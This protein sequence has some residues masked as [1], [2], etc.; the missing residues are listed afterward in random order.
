MTDY[1]KIQDL[2]KILKTN[3]AK[4]YNPSEHLVVEEAIVKFKGSIIFKQ[5]IPKKMLFQHQNVQ[6]SVTPVVIP[7][8]WICIWVKTKREAQHLTATH[9][10][11]TNLTRRVGVGHKLYMDNFFPPLTYMMT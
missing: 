3:F 9:A 4:F 11:V 5:Y 8:T 7:V 1:W 10:T 6:N 2:F